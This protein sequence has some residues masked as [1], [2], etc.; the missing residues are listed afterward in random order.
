M[1]I[2]TIFFALLG[3]VMGLYEEALAFMPFA[4]MIALS[5]GYDP[6]VGLSLGLLGLAGGFAAH[7]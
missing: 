3:G 7:R 6:I 1:I 4:I 5:L 2:I